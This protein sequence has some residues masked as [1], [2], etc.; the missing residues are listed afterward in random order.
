MNCPK[1][2]SGVHAPDH[3]HCATQDG[4]DTALR[5]TCAYCGASMTIDIRHTAWE[6]DEDGD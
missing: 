5:A 4:I 1:S 6:V 3:I 2:P